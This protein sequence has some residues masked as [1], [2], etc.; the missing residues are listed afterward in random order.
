M[1]CASA[2]FA[3][4]SAA[5]PDFAVAWYSV[6]SIVNST[7]FALDRRAVLVALA[8]QVAAHARADVGVD[9]AVERADGF[10]V[11]RH[12][13]ALDGDHRTSAGGGG[14]CRRL[15][16]AAG[17]DEATRDDDERERSQNTHSASTSTASARACASW[18]SSSARLSSAWRNAWP[19]VT[20]SRLVP[21]PRA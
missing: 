16:V 21:R 1:S 8:L 2:T 5:S 20:R 13:A 7:W 9:V 3:R 15:V 14:W 6:G 4:D 11:E 18:N 12:V 17:D 10:D 19:D